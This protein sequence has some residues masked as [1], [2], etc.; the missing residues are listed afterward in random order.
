MAER[1][2]KLSDVPVWKRAKYRAGEYM[3]APPPVSTW[4]WTEVDWINYIG[5]H[6]LNT[7]TAKEVASGHVA[8]VD[9]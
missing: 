7:H 5:D 1:Y 8:P 3:I 2:E 4:A 9:E 6:W